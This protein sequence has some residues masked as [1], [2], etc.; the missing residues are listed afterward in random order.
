MNH[1]SLKPIRLALRPSRQLAGLLG[2]AGTAACAAILLLPALPWVKLM[3]AAVVAA[4]TLYYLG[5]DALL[6]MPGSIVALEVTSNGALRCLS[7]N[8][9][10]LDVSVRG[11]S[12]VTPWLTVLN[13]TEPG[14]RLA[15][16]AI[17]LSDSGDADVFRS[18]RVWLRWGSQ[19]FPGK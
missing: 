2:V 4:T 12:F 9:L 1:Y 3:L 10:W 17:L 19:A 14:K 5:H 6:R 7:R 15:K 16:R 13:L 8:G 18:L 11:D